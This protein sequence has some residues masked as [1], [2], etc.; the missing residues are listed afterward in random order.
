MN[1]DVLLWTLWATSA[2]C[3]TFINDRREV[4]LLPN[5]ETNVAP[6]GLVGSSQ[7]NFNEYL[8]LQ[9]ECTPQLDTYIRIH[10]GLLNLCNGLQF[11]GKIT[12]VESYFNELAVTPTGIPD[13]PQSVTYT[14]KSAAGQKLYTLTQRFSFVETLTLKSV[15]HTFDFNPSEN[16]RSQ[17]M[18][19]VDLGPFE[20]SGLNPDFEAKL[21]TEPLWLRTYFVGS[22]LYFKVQTDSR[23]AD[24]DGLKFRV[25]E[26]KTGLKS[27]E[28]FWGLRVTNSG[29]ETPLPSQTDTAK[30][31]GSKPGFLRFL[32]FFIVAGGL[33]YFF[34]IYRK[35]A[36]PR[37]AMSPNPRIDV[38]PKA[39][40]KMDDLH[41]DSFEIKQDVLTDSVITWN[42]DLMAKKAGV[43]PRGG[44]GTVLISEADLEADHGEANPDYNSGVFGRGL[45]EISGIDKEPGHRRGSNDGQSAFLDGLNI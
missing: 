4:F 35:P 30:S 15:R 7:D 5:I 42:K 10:A 26:K 17:I 36:T 13:T 1:R 44:E 33:L 38:T 20:D 25:I 43:R 37:P 39:F 22:S 24:L 41:S 34:C 3:L 8:T 32:F 18:A 16:G 29:P 21:Q 2:A 28:Q 45:E 12:D 14:L 9:I 6:F 19:T 23:L 27:E 11:R 31:E 40:Q